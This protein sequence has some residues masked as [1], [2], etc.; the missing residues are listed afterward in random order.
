MWP[1]TTRTRPRFPKVCRSAS[2]ALSRGSTSAG[3][4]QERLQSGEEGVGS[5]SG[6]GPSNGRSFRKPTTGLAVEG[7]DAFDGG[8]I[9]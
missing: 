6:G 4:E 5:S 7:L 8:T 2:H 9:R 1:T 3:E